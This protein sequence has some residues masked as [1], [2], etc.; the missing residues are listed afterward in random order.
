MI[1]RIKYFF[2]NFHLL[3]NFAPFL[4]LLAGIAFF[5]IYYEHYEGFTGYFLSGKLGIEPVDDFWNIAFI[6]LIKISYYLCKYYPSVDWYLF[7]HIF[8]LCTVF[9]LLNYCIAKIF[10]PKNNLFQIVIVSFLILLTWY[11][12][13]L[14]Y[15]NV[16]R[17][18]ILLSGLSLFILIIKFSNQLEK[19]NFFFYFFLLFCFLIGV[20]TRIESAALSITLVVLTF[21]CWKNFKIFFTWKIFI[22][23]CYFTL[24]A[25][26]VTISRITDDRFFVK[27]DFLQYIVSDSPYYHKPVNFNSAKDSMIYLAVDNY[28]IN[29]TENINNELLSTLEIEKIKITSPDFLSVFTNHLQQTFNL[30]YKLLITELYYFSIYIVVFSV[31]LLLIKKKK[32]IPFFSLHLFFWLIIIGLTYLIKMESRV[33][34]SLFLIVIVI[35]LAIVNENKTFSRKSLWF[36]A[37]FFTAVSVCGFIKF[38]QSSKTI[39]KI[40]ENNYR[41]MEEINKEL[42]NKYVLIDVES[43]NLFI[44]PVFKRIKID[45]SI[46]LIFY[47]MGQLPLTKIGKDHHDKICNCNSSV[48]KE[49]YDFLYQNKENVVFVSNKKR[50]TFVFDYL[51][52]VHAL[53]YASFKLLPGD[54]NLGE[55]SSSMHLNLSY[56]SFGDIQGSYSEI[57]Q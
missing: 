32:T 35:S 52:I 28:L 14:L 20:H 19:T 24:L 17:H 11:G 1:T 8:C 21:L 47:D 45:P 50:M 9:Y 57:G 30:I 25:A 10:I 26:Y 23:L 33:L 46:K 31:S 51:R 53:N 37:I 42:K 55:L 39:S 16:T 38:Y 56:Y 49:F 15:L 40:P 29:D 5:G 3:K 36:L 18:S 43:S 7:F 27:S 22:P 6:G 2:L 34:N 44:H 13:N 54:Y 12:D 48:N 41:A 4:V